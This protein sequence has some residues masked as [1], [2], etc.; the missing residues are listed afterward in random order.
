MTNQGQVAEHYAHGRLIE[1]IEA[2]LA[3]MSKTTEQVTIDDLGPV[4]EFH[5]GGRT[6]T[7][8]FLDQLAITRD[9][10]VLDVGS[11]IG[12]ASRF[13]SDRYGAR[14]AGIDLTAE[15]VDTAKVLS[16]WVGLS[17]RVAFHHGSALEQPFA[18]ASFDAAFMLHVGMNIA[19]KAALF[20]EIWRVLKPGG[21]L[22]IYDVMRI[23][24]GDLTFPVPWASEPAASALAV[25]AN[26]EAGLGEVGFDI[27]AT[28]DR[29]DFAIGFF[30]DLRARASGADGPPP[31][32]L[33]ILMGDQ[34]RT[35][36]ANMIANIERG[37]IAPVE[38]I[39]TRPA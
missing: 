4:D 3:N 13:I 31:L 33:H 11:G 32:G 6:A 20:G 2:G 10:H 19:D 23:G 34:A 7:S 5:I 26:Y 18:D 27:R 12:G 39:A 16:A 25:P 22:G 28:R 21:V 37:V 35:K 15:F 9:H 36:V 29:R 1:A 8:E 14:V 30:N 38:I 17:D 24:D